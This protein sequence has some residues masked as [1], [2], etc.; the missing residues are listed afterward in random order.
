MSRNNLIPMGFFS[1]LQ[2]VPPHHSFCFSA[3]SLFHSGPRDSR[4]PFFLEPCIAPKWSDSYRHHSKLHY[5]DF[6]R[7]SDGRRLLPRPEYP[8][9]NLLFVNFS[10]SSF[11]LIKG[12]FELFLHSQSGSITLSM[13]LFRKRECGGGGKSLYKSLQSILIF[14]TNGHIDVLFGCIHLSNTWSQGKAMWGVPV[15]SPLHLLL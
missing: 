10:F 15:L 5:R 13:I 6:Q 2:F 1:P 3:L 12:M 14:W 11:F 9:L 4:S 7:S 8:V